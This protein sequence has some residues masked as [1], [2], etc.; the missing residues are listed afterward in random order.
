MLNFLHRNKL[1]LIKYNSYEYNHALEHTGT[2][3]LQSVTINMFKNKRKQMRTFVYLIRVAS[4]QSG[5]CTEQSVSL[6]QV[7]T[8]Y[9]LH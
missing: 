3:L 2:H 8:R 6:L 5:L 7:A 9:P 4:V 1:H